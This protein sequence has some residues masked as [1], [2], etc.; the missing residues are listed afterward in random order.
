MKSGLGFLRAARRC[1]ISDL[2]RLTRT[3]ALVKVVSRL[4][5]TL[6]K[7]RGVSNIYLASRGARFAAQ[8]QQQTLE[9]DEMEAELRASLNNL[10]TAAGHLGNGAR[11]F[12]NIAYVLHGLDGLCDLRQRIHAL[13]LRPAE[14][15]AA[16]VSLIKGLLAVVFEAADSAT[17][18]EIS[19]LLVAMFNFMQ[20]KEF[21]GQERAFGSATFAAGQI[22]AQSQQQWADLIQSQERCVK[23][24]HDFSTPQLR[25]LWQHCQDPAMLAEL[26]RLRRI[27]CSVAASALD[28]DLS[29]VWFDCAT[30][31]MEAMKTVEDQLAADL[32]SLCGHKIAQARDEL[33]NQKIIVAALTSTAQPSAPTSADQLGEAEPAY[34]HHL[35]RSILDMVQD[36]ASRLQAMSDELEAVRSS[37]TERKLVERAKGLLMARRK[38]SE[39][40]AYK[41][42]RQTAMSQNKRMT[43]VAQTVLAMADYLSTETP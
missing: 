13:T 22:D 24:F 37:L 12:S 40:D 1:E 39:E 7:E 34:G 3:S 21:S 19:R 2:E 8:L 11:L 30:R 32:L 27:A 43:D 29:Q 18:P 23:V 31:R 15:T 41:M 25:E 33:N 35:G 36:Q 14:A 16:F 5:H 38:L 9:C 4:V 17:H 42:L 10:D 26:E 6:Q 20:G 28:T